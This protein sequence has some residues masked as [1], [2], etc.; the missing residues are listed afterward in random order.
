MRLVELAEVAWRRGRG[1]AD[2]AA[3]AQAGIF[4]SGS[5]PIALESGMIFAS[6]KTTTEMTGLQVTLTIEQDQSSFDQAAR[7][8]LEAQL[9]HVYN[10]SS[11]LVNIEDVRAGSVVVAVY[12][13]AES[14][15]Q[16][17]QLANR[18]ASIDDNTLGTILNTNCSRS[19][20]VVQSRRNV[21]RVRFVQ[22]KCPPGHW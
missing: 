8:T 14:D 7:A 22:E 10:V 2:V 16:L 3:H 1:A 20:T 19:P 4:P 17:Q 12:L 6:E 13:A 11:D 15:A 18:V 5:L 21:T 9:A